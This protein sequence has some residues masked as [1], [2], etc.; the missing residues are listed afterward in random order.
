MTTNNDGDLDLSLTTP[1]APSKSDASNDVSQMTNPNAP[2]ATPA[3]LA[4]S[5]SSSPGLVALP[6]SLTFQASKV[7]LMKLI[8]EALQR[9]DNVS[10]RHKAKIEIIRRDL[11]KAHRMVNSGAPQSREHQLIVQNLWREAHTNHATDVAVW[12]ALKMILAA[13]RQHGDRVPLTLPDCRSIAELLAKAPHEDAMLPEFDQP[14]TR[15]EQ[16]RNNDFE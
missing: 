14:Q 6:V 2:A 3:A 4:P 1:N 9:E 5:S 7:S 11:E 8:T 15:Q 16:R 13:L 10:R 12:N